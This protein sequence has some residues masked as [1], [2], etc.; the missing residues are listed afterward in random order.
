MTPSAS[1][2]GLPTTG[3]GAGDDV[4]VA[5]AVQDVVAP[6]AQDRVSP[7]SA[8]DDVFTARAKIQ[9]APPAA[10]FLRAA[11]HSH[12][13]DDPFLR[14][15]SDFSSHTR[16]HQPDPWKKVMGRSPPIS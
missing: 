12:D 1:P 11:D 13:W 6:A 4:G 8:G 15:R 9:S 3:R 7:T 14:V 5:A 16:G 10:T 2:L